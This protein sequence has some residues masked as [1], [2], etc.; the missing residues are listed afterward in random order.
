[1]S[2]PVIPEWS[3]E[4]LVYVE[5]TQVVKSFGYAIGL[6]ARKPGTGAMGQDT[7]DLVNDAD[8]PSAAER[9]EY[10]DLETATAAIKQLALNFGAKLVGITHV[11]QKHVFKDMDVPHKYAIVS[12]VDM[13]YE[14]LKYVPDAERDADSPEDLGPIRSSNSEIGRVYNSV[15][16]IA[17]DL[18]KLIRARGYPAR[19]HTLRFE[20]LSMLPHAYAAGLGELG[21]HGS[22]INRTLG[23]TMRVSVVTTDLP[24]LEDS[25]V[26]EGLEAV[27]MNCKMC[28]DYCPGDA[29]S[30]EKQDVRGVLKW[31]VNTE[32]CAPYWGSYSACGICL[33]VCPV[34]ARAFEGRFKQ[35]FIKT[36]KS[37][38]LPTWREELK[39]GLQEPWSHVAKPTEFPDGWRMDVKAAGAAGQ[40]HRGIPVEGAFK[41]GSLLDTSLKSE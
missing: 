38:D 11:D 27:C 28:L 18:A 32:A 5:P 7:L 3:G 9:V 6:R 2:Q 34:N 1:M 14:T 10:P 30:H 26:D 31:V 37:I 23:S 29:I 36:I 39:E 24:L 13:E 12:A 41:D 20:Q 33:Q 25:P 40:L 4:D 16:H 15:G 21:K 22:L 19:A 17:T 35:S 8:G